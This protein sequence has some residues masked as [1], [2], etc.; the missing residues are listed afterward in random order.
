MFGKAAIAEQ[1]QCMA[2]LPH[3][4]STPKHV[5]TRKSDGP[6]QLQVSAM[7]CRGG[8]LSSGIGAVVATFTEEVARAMGPSVTRECSSRNDCPFVSP[9]A[10]NL[11]A[12]LVCIWC[13]PPAACAPLVVPK[14]LCLTNALYASVVNT[15]KLKTAALC[16]QYSDTWC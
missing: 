4:P 16:P 12:H 14:F 11:L 6:V 15:I 13:T 2:A 1:Q 7:S 3:M 10:P 8:Y 9:P 5:N